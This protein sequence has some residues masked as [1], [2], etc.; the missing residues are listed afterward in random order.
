MRTLGPR[1]AHRVF[2]DVHS[3]STH[4]AFKFFVSL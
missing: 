4:F 1:N 2:G 3:D